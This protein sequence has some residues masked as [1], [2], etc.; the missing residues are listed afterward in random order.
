MTE[1]SGIGLHNTALHYTAECL[2]KLNFSACDMGPV[3]H[4]QSDTLMTDRGT[5]KNCNIV[6]G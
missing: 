4:N 2:I 6:K 3:A 5:V 1:Y